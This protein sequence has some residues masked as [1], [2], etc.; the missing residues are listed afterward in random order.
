MREENFIRGLCINGQTIVAELAVAERFIKTL[1]V[2]IYKKTSA[3]ASK[4]YLDYLN[5]LSAFYDKKVI[6]C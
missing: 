1:K 6:M 2:K 5:K 3:T 4:C